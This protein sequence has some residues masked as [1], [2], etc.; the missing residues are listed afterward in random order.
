MDSNLFVD[1]LVGARGNV[2]NLG[3][4]SEEIIWL[5]CGAGLATLII[6]MVGFWDNPNVKKK[7]LWQR[8]FLHI[9]CLEKGFII[10]C[11]N[12]ILSFEGRRRGFLKK[13]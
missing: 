6:A 9:I 11:S 12:I 4:S 7:F 1:S 13:S 10:P 8:Q 5:V 3:L 2:A